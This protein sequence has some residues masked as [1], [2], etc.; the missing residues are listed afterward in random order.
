[1]KPIK[2]AEYIDILKYKGF[3]IKLVEN[4]KGKYNFTSGV[5]SYPNFLKIYLNGEHMGKDVFND[6]IWLELEDCKKEI[7]EYLNKRG[8]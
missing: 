7:D 6:V 5:C 2:S 3:D 8:R 1:M 4:S